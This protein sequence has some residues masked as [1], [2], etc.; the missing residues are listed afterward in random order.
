MPLFGLDQ[1][2]EIERKKPL[3]AFAAGLKLNLDIRS[4][5]V[6]NPDSEIVAV[7]VVTN[8][9]APLRPPRGKSLTDIDRCGVEP[10]RTLFLVPLISGYL[11]WRRLLSLATRIFGLLPP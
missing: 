6:C 4:P 8:L 7:G 11:F 10:N 9:V 3:E 5:V 1:E 2:Y